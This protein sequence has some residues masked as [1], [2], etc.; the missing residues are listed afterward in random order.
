MPAE[1][2]GISW[3]EEGPPLSPNHLS[4]ALDFGL[5]CSRLE[6]AYRRSFVPGSLLL[7]M[8]EDREPGQAP[9][10]STLLGLSQPLPSRL[11]PLSLLSSAAP[12]SHS[13]KP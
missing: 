10:F 12:S 3:L 8:G 5:L 13:Q 9:G 6:A 7:P 2:T 1:C 11:R 4:S